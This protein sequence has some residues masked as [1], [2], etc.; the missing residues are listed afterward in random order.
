[1]TTQGLLDLRQTLLLQFKFAT[2]CNTLVKQTA[3][4]SQSI[5]ERKMKIISF[6]IASY[7]PAVMCHL[8]VV[9]AL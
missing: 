3:V 4:G 7:S 2:S 1:M 8:I 6:R 5:W 9:E